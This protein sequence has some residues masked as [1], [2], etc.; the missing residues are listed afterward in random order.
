M[1]A[2]NQLRKWIQPQ[3]LQSSS[4]TRLKNAST[5]EFNNGV[6]LDDFFLEEHIDALQKVIDEEAI[7]KE[8]FKLFTEKDPVPK[9][10]F[11]KAPEEERFLF[12]RYIHEVKPEYRKSKNWKKYREFQM[13]YQFIFPSY[14]K[15]FADYPL[16]LDGHFT[17]S[18]QDIHYLKP[19]CDKARKRKVCTVLYLSRGWK[20]EY[21]GELHMACN[22]KNEKIIYPQCN[23]LLLFFPSQT[24]P[25]YVAR[26]TEIAK[27]K[28]RTCH[29]AWYGV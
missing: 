8:H 18:H 21:G 19:H 15:M 6:L 26:H 25:H 23:R 17:H 7:Y 20:P 2:F 12:R 14:L 10:V 22:S 13:F 3:H 4:I 1:S 9:E 29:V 16:L 11:M 24:S 27:H 28:T 5:E